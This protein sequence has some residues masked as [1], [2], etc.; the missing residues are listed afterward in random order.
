MYMTS[1]QLYVLCIFQHA[2]TIKKQK[3]ILISEYGR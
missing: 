2:I 3:Q 1:T